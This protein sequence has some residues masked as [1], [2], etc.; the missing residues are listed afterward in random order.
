MDEKT[1]TSKESFQGPLTEKHDGLMTWAVQG[2]GR[3]IADHL[4][5]ALLN[6]DNA[7]KQRSEIMNEAHNAAAAKQIRRSVLLAEEPIN[8]PVNV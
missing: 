3:Y 7:T 8:S 5:N 1:H 6:P 4:R 2:Y